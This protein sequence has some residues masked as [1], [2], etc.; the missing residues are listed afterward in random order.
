MSTREEMTVCNRPDNPKGYVITYHEIRGYDSPDRWYSAAT[1][2]GR[3]IGEFGTYG[4]AVD[5]CKKD[6]KK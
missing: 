6:K 4:E 1:K 2:R 3:F 5:A